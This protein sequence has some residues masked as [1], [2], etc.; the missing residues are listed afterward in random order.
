[1]YFHFEFRK[2][3]L[4]EQI[5]L[6]TVIYSFKNQLGVSKGLQANIEIPL[7]HVRWENYFPTL[8]NTTVVWWARPSKV[9]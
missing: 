6:Y 4:L 3:S 9:R 8:S 1:M 7:V 2:E 5:L